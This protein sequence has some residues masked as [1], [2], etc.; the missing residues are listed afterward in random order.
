MLI[1]HDVVYID[2]ESTVMLVSS[3]ILLFTTPCT[4]SDIGPARWFAF[5]LSLPFA[6]NSIFFFLWFFRLTKKKER[7]YCNAPAAG[8]FSRH[9]ASFSR[10]IDEKTNQQKSYFFFI[11][12]K[13]FFI[14]LQF[15]ER[16][17]WPFPESQ[18]WD[19][20]RY[21][22]RLP[23]WIVDRRWSYG[24]RFGCTHN[25]WNLS[26]KRRSYFFFFFYFF[27]SFFLFKH[28]KISLFLSFL[29]C[30]TGIALAHR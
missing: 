21:S 2:S 27:L 9:V 6:Q 7:Q 1:H 13:S 12:S 29:I 15:A 10:S 25:G 5:N 19:L 23:L 30:A 20:M 26:N 3:S 8:L 11:I 24:N 28:F 4:V 16:S 17:I 18:R 14:F 22:T